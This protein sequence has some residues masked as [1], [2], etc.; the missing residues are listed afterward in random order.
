ADPALQRALGWAKTEEALPIALARQAFVRGEMIW[1]GD[2]RMIY[3]IGRDGRWQV[4]PDTFVEGEPEQD[5]AITPPDGLFQPIRGFGKLWRSDPKVRERTGWA[6]AKEQGYGGFVQEFER[7]LLISGGDR[8][9]ALIAQDGNLEM[10]T[11]WN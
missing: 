10:G 5:P 11:V 2:T 4:H 9:L 1:R 8:T 6:L 3:V 7:G